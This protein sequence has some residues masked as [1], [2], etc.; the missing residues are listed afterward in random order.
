MEKTKISCPYRGAVQ[1]VK[2]VKL[3]LYTPGQALRAARG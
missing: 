2:K 3:S 1:P